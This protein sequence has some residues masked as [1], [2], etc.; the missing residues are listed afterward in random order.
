MDTIT[1]VGEL[2]SRQGK[3][4]I[5]FLVGVLVGRKQIVD[6]IDIVAKERPLDAL[7]VSSMIRASWQKYPPSCH[8]KLVGVIFRSS[9]KDAFLERDTPAR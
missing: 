9:W 8:P 3:L 6:Y 2:L 7:E 4:S 1:V 5:G